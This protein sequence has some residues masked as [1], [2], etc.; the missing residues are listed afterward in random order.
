MS[1]EG[2]DQGKHRTVLHADRGFREV[3]SDSYWVVAITED[4]PGFKIVSEWSSLDEA[5]QQ[6]K[7]YN[8]QLGLTDDEVRAIRI[9]SMRA[10]IAAEEE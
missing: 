9:S 3:G 8:A 7:G 4:E 1:A 5:M 6:A 2:N 10:S